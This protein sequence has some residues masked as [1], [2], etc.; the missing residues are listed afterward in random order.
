MTPCLSRPA[1][2]APRARGFTLIEMLVVVAI[3]GILAAIA[4]PAYGKY[5]VKSNRAA[6][7]AH[8]M[9]LAQA[10]AQYM[11]DSRAYAA[12]DALHVTTPA[13]VSS[14]YDIEIE[15]TDGPPS[16]FVITA[17]PKT[18]TNQADD[19]NLTIDSSGARTPEAK[20]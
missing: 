11:A 1:P 5:L 8:L 7:Q 4:Y 10:E 17:T 19:G 12:L 18:G 20:W 13:A 3:I 2:P 14:K 15:V 9:D 6:A 16:T